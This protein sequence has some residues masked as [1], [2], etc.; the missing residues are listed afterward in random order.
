[1]CLCG[2]G[3]QAGNQ[4][5]PGLGGGLGVQSRNLGQTFANGLGHVRMALDESGEDPLD[6]RPAPGSGRPVG[7]GGGEILAQAHEDSPGGVGMLLEPLVHATGLGGD[8]GIGR[9][10]RRAIAVAGGRCG[11]SA[12]TGRDGT[13]TGAMS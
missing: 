8:V 11:A 5:P 2:R 10:T 4:V 1:M 6:L 3:T 7:G 13:I 12:V 9:R